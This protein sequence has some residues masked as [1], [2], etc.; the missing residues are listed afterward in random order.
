MIAFDANYNKLDPFETTT[1]VLYEE[2]KKNSEFKNQTAVNHQ[3]SSML[4]SQLTP[5]SAHSTSALAAMASTNAA[6]TSFTTGETSSGGLLH[7]YHKSA[8]ISSFLSSNGLTGGGSGQGANTVGSSSAGPSSA[9]RSS[10]TFCL[11]VS[12]FNLVPSPNCPPFSDENCELC[13][14]L[15][16]YKVKFDILEFY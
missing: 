1:I 11:Q 2:L 16:L 7:F 13:V 15:F 5:G 12:L 3:Y 10:S 9:P 8:A 6:D 4:M 14:N